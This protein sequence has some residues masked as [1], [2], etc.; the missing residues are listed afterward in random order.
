MW[1]LHSLSVFIRHCHSGSSS[2]HYLQMIP[3]FRLCVCIAWG[4]GPL[5]PA[6]MT[7]LPGASICMCRVLG[8]RRCSGSI[9]L[10]RRVWRRVSP[11]ASQAQCHALVLSQSRAAAA[12]GRVQ[13]CIV[14][15]SNNG[16]FLGRAT[17]TLAV[18]AAQ[19]Q[20]KFYIV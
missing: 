4:A 16:V 6:W 20:A 5:R 7:Y 13:S 12:S 10:P 17:S 1:N 3:M 18:E 9:T 15:P 19:T 8:R 14:R 2:L 11:N